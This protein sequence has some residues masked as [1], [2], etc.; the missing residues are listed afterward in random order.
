MQ[1]GPRDFPGED[2]MDFEKDNFEDDNELSRLDDE[3]DGQESGEEESRAKE[4]DKK[5]ETQEEG[6]QKEDQE[7]GEEEKEAISLSRPICS[8]KKLGLSFR[9]FLL[10]I[11]PPGVEA[12]KPCLLPKLNAALLD[13]GIG[14][15]CEAWCLPEAASTISMTSHVAGPGTDTPDAGR[16]TVS[17]DALRRWLLLR[18]Q[19]PK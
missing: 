5:I 18:R 6:G 1:A 14:Y 16:C 17:P 9:L 7:S 4:K 2:G 10:G 19:I 8:R 12:Q 13:S 15:R 3:E 11:A